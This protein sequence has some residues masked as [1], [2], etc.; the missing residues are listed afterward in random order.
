MLALRLAVRELRG[1]AGGFI[2]LL[3]GI[4]FG[5]AAIAAIGL[6]SAAVLDG[7]REGARTSIGGDVSLRLFH[8]PPAPEHLAAFEAAGTVSLTAEMRTLARRDGRS[9][10]VELTAPSGWTRLW[11]RP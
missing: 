10:L 5:T 6:L 1:S 8:R 2:F 7:M 4:A 3:V 11:R 9:A